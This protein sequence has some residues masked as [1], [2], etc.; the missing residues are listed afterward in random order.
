MNQIDKDN[1]H[2]ERIGKLETAVTGINNQLDDI[3]SL[4]R[5]MGN[6]ISKSRRTDWSV[7]FAGALVVGGLWAAA[8]HPISSDVERTSMAADRLAQAV[9]VQNER[10]TTL[11][12]QTAILQWRLDHTDK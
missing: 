6:E 8:I 10:Q 9:V 7:V 5:T 2:A 4:L 3:T 1:N 11:V 12:V